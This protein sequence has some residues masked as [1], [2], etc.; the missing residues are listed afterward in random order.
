MRDVRRSRVRRDL[1]AGEQPADRLAVGAVERARRPT[2]RRCSASRSARRVVGVDVHGAG[3]VDVRVEDVGGASLGCSPWKAS[4]ISGSPR[5][6][7]T[8]LKR[9][10]C[11]F[12]PSV[13]NASVMPNALSPLVVAERIVAS[14]PEVLSA[15]TETSPSVVVD[16][17]ARR[18]TRRLA[19]HD[20]RGDLAADR[21]HRARAVEAAARGDDVELPRRPSAARSRAP[22]LEPS[23]R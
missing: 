14:M 9:M 12:Q 2:S 6:A 1:V 5:S 22:R 16:A 4:A 20:V 19:E 11:D 8:V 17:A 10:F 7:S 3:R 18:C 23:R 21:E 15:V 13:L